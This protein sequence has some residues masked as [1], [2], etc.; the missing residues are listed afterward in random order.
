MTLMPVDPVAETQAQR[1][2]RAAEAV[3]A[4]LSAP[5]IVQR[6]SAA[7]GPSDWSVL[8]I[9]GHTVEMIPYWLNHCRALI[10]ATGAPPFGRTHDSPERLA[11]V[12]QG[13]ASSPAE[14]LLRLD[15]EVQAA[16]AAIRAM[17]PADRARTGLHP[18]HGEMTVAA[19]IET[20]IV[21]HAEE[22]LAQI[23]A[24]LTASGA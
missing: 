3:S 1:L 11:G 15:E 16:A 9:L 17:S 21:S 14:L 22:H 19:V 5:G 13:A 20:F 10:A 6:L 18:R 24:N 4:A 12:A 8:E 2:E 7:P 23:K